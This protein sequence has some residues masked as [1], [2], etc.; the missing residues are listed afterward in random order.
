MGSSHVKAAVIGSDT[1]SRA[2]DWIPLKSG[3]APLL[4]SHID[5]PQLVDPGIVGHVTTPAAA[6]FG[7][8][9]GTPVVMG[10]GDAGSAADRDCR[11]CPPA[12]SNCT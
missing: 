11:H 1:H 5:R 3:A 2:G 10:L 12:A 8:P 9:A 7:V 6:T 4:P